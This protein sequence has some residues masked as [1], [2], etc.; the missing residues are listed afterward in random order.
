M[1]IPKP[2]S[3][4]N[5]ARYRLR[6][7]ESPLA[8]TAL[9]VFAIFTVSCESSEE[10]ATP[11][12][13]AP[14]T[15]SS[16]PIATPDV[17]RI[18]LPQDEQGYWIAEDL[19]RGR[20]QVLVQKYPSGS[21]LA[22]W[23]P[24]VGLLDLGSE[25]LTTLKVLPVGDQL[26]PRANDGRFV[27]WAEVGT[28][29]VK[30]TR[31]TI[32]L[33]DLDSGAIEQ[34]DALPAELEPPAS[35]YGPPLA[36]DGGRLLFTSLVADGS[37]VRQELRLRDLSSGDESVLA[38][39][40]LSK[41]QIMQVAMSGDHVLFLESP[42]GDEPGTVYAIDLQQPGLEPDALIEDARS[43]AISG[44]RVLVWKTDGLYAGQ[45][46]ELEQVY[47]SN[48]PQVDL[49]LIPSGGVWVDQGI[50]RA[51]M[52]D[53]AGTVRPLSSVYTSRVM[54]D[55]TFLV[56]LEAPELGEGKR[57]EQFYL[58]WIKL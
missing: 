11:T 36:L 17:T 46:G 53:A 27:A 28:F 20:K 9:L 37:D 49:A 19:I 41:G 29:G 24:A 47:D 21:D 4:S 25:T 38:D 7:L 58:V 6:A 31:W 3:Q 2:T 55:G 51:M 34:V 54:T 30:E 56:W 23:A 1:E 57:A 43:A 14:A 12:A 52:L 44:P 39:V 18:E 33:L 45:I 13:S 16:T 10:G 40:L 32:Q 8:L 48:A 15:M 35:G 22:G 26:G 50:H 42:A 5:D